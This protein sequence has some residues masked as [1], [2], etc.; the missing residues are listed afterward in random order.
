MASSKN[1]IRKNQGT[2]LEILLSAV[3]AQDKNAFNTLYD[4]TVDRVYNLALKITLSPDLA[5]EVLSDVYFYVW[6]QAH[7]YNRERRGVMAWLMVLCRSRAIDLL[8]K[9]KQLS[10]KSEEFSEENHGQSLAQ[11]D[12]LNTL[13]NE[14][15]VHKALKMLDVQQR[16]LLALAYFGGYSHNE[17]VNV[18]GL[19]LGT[20]KTNLRRSLVFLK[21]QLAY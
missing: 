6:Q 20:V 11:P 3:K 17:L 14:S 15:A 9:N 13:E 7:K 10:A 4:E 21:E 12:F 16:Q 8:R 1:K 19:P 18:T 5:E 2:N